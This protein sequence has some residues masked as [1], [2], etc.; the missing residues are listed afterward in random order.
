[1]TQ[2]TIDGAPAVLDATDEA[3]VTRRTTSEIVKTSGDAVKAWVKRN[4]YPITVSSIGVLLI[5][6][7][8]LERIFVNIPPGHVGVLWKRLMEGTVTDQIY[9]EGLNIILPFNVMY[10]YDTRIQQ[11]T[12]SYQAISSDGLMMNVEMSV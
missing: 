3:P 11:V 12:D 5:T 2:D 10:A 1:M 6:V 8:L 7:F 4:V 9:G